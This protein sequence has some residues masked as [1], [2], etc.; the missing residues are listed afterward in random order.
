MRLLSFVISVF[1]MIAGL[2]L[3][4]AD[5]APRALTLKEAI[6]LSA[7][8][9]PVE[10]ARLDAA[11]A[12]AGFGAERSGL[13]P[14]IDAVAGWVGSASTSNSATTALPYHR[15][16]PSMHVCASAKRCSTWKRGIARK[17]LIVD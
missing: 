6:S 14:Q 15:R 10:L 12:R 5:P 13:R 1:A 9:A 7:S 16:I 4:A 17:P 2:P 8:V 3:S 11:I